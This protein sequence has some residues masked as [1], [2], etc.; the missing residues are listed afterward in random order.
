MRKLILDEAFSQF[1]G[2]EF[3]NSDFGY[4]IQSKSRYGRN[5][6]WWGIQENRDTEFLHIDSRL[7]IRTGNNRG[8]ELENA[9]F[10]L[11]SIKIELQKLEIMILDETYVQHRRTTSEGVNFIFDIQ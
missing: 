7:G 2:S 6:I 5:Y 10:R 11:H 9:G 1:R 8:A 3:S 4:G